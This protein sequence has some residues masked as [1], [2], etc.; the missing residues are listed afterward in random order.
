[1]SIVPYGGGTSLEGHVNASHGGIAISFD[2]VSWFFNTS[3][4]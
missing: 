4:K 2:N 3:H 1:M